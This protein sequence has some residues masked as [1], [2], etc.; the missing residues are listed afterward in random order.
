LEKKKKNQPKKLWGQAQVEGK[1]DKRSLAQG[2]PPSSN[3]ESGN[4][5]LG[6]KGGKRGGEKEN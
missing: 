6:H 1:A 2:A 4:A 3:L 5:G